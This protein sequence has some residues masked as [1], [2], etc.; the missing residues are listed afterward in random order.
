MGTVPFK[1]KPIAEILADAEA[2]RRAPKQQQTPKKRAR[3]KGKPGERKPMWA[4]LGDEPPISEQEPGGVKVAQ[5]D[6]EESPPKP[7]GDVRN[8]RGYE[9]SPEVMERLDEFSQ[10][11]DKPVVITGGDRPSTSDIGAGRRSQHVVGTAADIYVPDQTHLETA[12]Q[13]LE[14][15]MFN[16]V[17]WYEEG[18]RGPNG[19]G[20]HVHVDLRPLSPEDPP[21]QWGQPKDGPPGRIPP[22]NPIQE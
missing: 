10:T 8:P 20:P 11:I 5:A 4:I 1:P 18:Y 13:A 22:F 7:Q 6:P 14:S 2:K 3:W 15:G 12:N 19:E 16:G 21:K 9:V 17:G